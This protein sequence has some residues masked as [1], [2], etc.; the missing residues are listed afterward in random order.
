MEF[1]TATA[2]G[3]AC[4]IPFSYT[5]AKDFRAPK[6]HRAKY[7]ERAVE[8]AFYSLNVCARATPTCDIYTSGDAYLV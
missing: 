3:S 1:L 2:R 4:R 8:L 6:L 7:I 5:G